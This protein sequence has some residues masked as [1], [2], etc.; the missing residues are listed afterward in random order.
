MGQ[1]TD[2]CVHL[3]DCARPLGLSN[4]VALE[5][6]QMVMEWLPSG[7]RGLVPKGRFDGLSLRATDQDWAWGSGPQVT[8]PSEA[9]AMAMTGR[10]AALADL[11]GTGVR[12]LSERISSS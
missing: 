3:R 12:L 7:V 5:D 4:D 6:W 1:M 11:D 10:V 9:L 8:C 2:G